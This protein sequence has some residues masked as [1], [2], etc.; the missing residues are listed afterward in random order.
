M[1]IGLAKHVFH[2]RINQSVRMALD[3]TVVDHD[4]SAAVLQDEP[5]AVYTRHHIRIAGDQ[6]I[7][8]LA[9]ADLRS[10]NRA[11][12]EGGLAERQQQHQKRTDQLTVTFTEF[13]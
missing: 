9:Q 10:P 3:P 11:G 6:H 5:V 1:R 13:S 8:P 12:P 7:Q 4:R 2:I